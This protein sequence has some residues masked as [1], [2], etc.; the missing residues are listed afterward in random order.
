MVAQTWIEESRKGTQSLDRLKYK[1]LPVASSSKRKIRTLKEPDWI[2]KQGEAYTWL[3]FDADAAAGRAA[4]TLAGSALT[5]PWM[6][7]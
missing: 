1:K 2:T 5:A 3:E 7:R 6:S 4:Q